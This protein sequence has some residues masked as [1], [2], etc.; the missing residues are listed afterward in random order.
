MSELR[1]ELNG[2]CKR[3]GPTVALDSVDLALRPGEV[4]AL[5]GENG[6]GKST[7]MKVLSGAYRPDAGEMRLSG[8]PYAPRNPQEGR[9]AGVAMIY[10]ELSLAQDLTVM[11]NVLLG[12]EPKAGPL[13]KWKEL[14]RIAAD[15]LRE[16]GLEHLS[17]SRKVSVL[18]PAEQQLVEIARSV[19]IGCDV[20]V[21][22]EPTSSL[23]EK[24]IKKLYALI[25][26][27]KAQGRSIVYI[28][29]FMEEIMEV[30][31]RFTVLR[32]GRSVGAGVTAEASTRAIIALMVG[33][34][35]DDL[36]PRSERVAGE[37]VLRTDRLTGLRKPEEVSVELRRG[38]VLGIFGLVGAGRTEFMR[39]LFGLDPVN[40]GELTV[41]ALSGFACPSKQWR[42][43]VGMVSEDRKREG[44]AFGLSIADNIT[45]P[46]LGGLAPLPGWISPRKQ[47]EA[48]RSWIDLIPIK[49]ES[50][51]Q[52]VDK[53]SGG[54]Q[55]KVAIARLLYADVD[56]L[57][58]DEP[59]RGIDVGSKAQ[60]YTLIDGL[61][62]GDPERGI[63]PKA[64]L[65]ISSYLPELLGV[66]DRVAVMSKGRLGQGRCVTELD[67][68]TIMR[69]ATAS[70][71]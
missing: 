26:R 1:L 17:L 58:L 29:H 24:D 5:I 22:D 6:A 25:R 21:L 34:D 42:R 60:I 50:P 32:D 54:N 27:F 40:A 10:Q 35:V 51:G 7:L 43:G 8:K 59:T 37:T 45:L 70:G 65:M 52:P 18:S 64:V 68:H 4:H 19:A 14:R 38:E 69:E 53:L 30:A 47:R 39:C 63:K 41:H 62:K 12:I 71:G 13:I 2:M 56:I 36:Y 55:Q 46:R 23:T 16:V 15:A 11:E 33:R 28:S 57:L 44:L 48:C 9:H 3:F 61:A 67:E 31:D 49:C 66:C 20:L